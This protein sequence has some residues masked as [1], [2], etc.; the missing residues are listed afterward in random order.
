M[1]LF[2]LLLLCAA[3]LAS[4]WGTEPTTVTPVP[5]L[6]PR[7]YD[8][9]GALGNEGFKV[10]DGA[11]RGVLQGRK[12][13]RL[14]VNLF[15]GNQY[16]F[17]VATS[18]TGETP[19]LSLRGPSGEMVELV[20]FEKDGVAAAGVTAAAT[21]RYVLEIDGSGPGSRDF[22]LLYLFK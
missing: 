14:A 22:C 6:R 20:P 3:S 17:C 9:A 16:W 18:A 21:G 2:L 11:W 7:L 8:I 12:P 10:R 13:Q 1:K 4:A 5:G 19:S 15:S